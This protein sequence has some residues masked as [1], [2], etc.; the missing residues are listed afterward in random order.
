VL[1]EDR[2]FEHTKPLVLH[3][4]AV[5]PADWRF[6]FLGS[7]A[8]VA[9]L[10]TSKAIQHNERI[11]KLD[12]TVLPNN[13]STGDQERLSYVLTHPWFYSNML[14][15][16]AEFMLFFQTDSILCSN[17]EKTVDDYLEY[18]W[19]GAP[20]PYEPPVDG[21]TFPLS[22]SPSSCHWSRASIVS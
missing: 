6:V 5:V 17:A 16:E 8:S 18:A 19:V 1:I 15:K 12:M 10:N 11:G 20:W 21:Y 9:S 2:A 3:F 7:T 14:P 22:S 4:M 13:M